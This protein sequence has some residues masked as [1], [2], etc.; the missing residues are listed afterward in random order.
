M[1]NNDN[2]NW[3]KCQLPDTIEHLFINYE[4]SATFWMYID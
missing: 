2:D 1:K 4:H 3:L